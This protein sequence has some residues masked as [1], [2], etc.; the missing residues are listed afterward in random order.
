MEGRGNFNVES[1]ITGLVTPPDSTVTG[2]YRP[3]L[4]LLRRTQASQPQNGRVRMSS[5]DFASLRRHEAAAMCPA[6]KSVVCE[7][8]GRFMRYSCRYRKSCVFVL[9]LI[10]LAGTPVPA[11]QF[12]SAARVLTGQVTAESPASYDGLVVELTAQNR[13]VD[14]THVLPDGGF[15]FRGIANGQYEFRVVTLYGDTIHR[16][17]VSVQENAGPVVLRL[18]ARKVQLPV[19]GRVSIKALQHPVPGKAR[20]EFARSEKAYNEGRVED[21]IRHLDTAIRIHPNYAEAHNNLGARHMRMNNFA[22]A[23]R[24]FHRATEIDPGMGLAQAN[25]AL[26]FVSLN[27]GAEA[28]AAARRALQLAPSSAQASY[29]LGLSLAARSICSWEA[30]ERLQQSSGRFP[31]ARL[32]TAR[33]QLCRGNLSGAAAELRAYLAMPDAERRPEVQRWLREV[34]AN[35]SE[36]SFAREVR[37]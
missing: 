5:F 34:E 27:Q 6:F 7:K 29:A 2:I 10:A 22:E 15:E 4:Y 18:P 16:D 19:S 31:K 35:R 13:A 23:A 3:S 8:K 37:Q 28:E 26:A 36:T 1:S 9:P 11:Q 14:R 32:A 12:V 21:S 25:L 24:A 17:F 33:V 20:K 30:L